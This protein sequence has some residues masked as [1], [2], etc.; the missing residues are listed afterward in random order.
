[1]RV[2][3]TLPPLAWLAREVG[4][5]RLEVLA[6][7]DPR[8]DPEV[9]MLTPAA[10]RALANADVVFAVG[11]GVLPF[12]QQILPSLVRAG[13]PHVVAVLTEPE[14]GGE[15]PR[16]HRDHGAHVTRDPHAWLDP[17]RMLDAAHRLT[18]RLAELDPPAAP[19]YRQSLALL[20]A[21]VQEVDE[22]IR[23]R[24]AASDGGVLL[25]EHPTWEVLARR[26]RTTVL[27]IE[28]EEREPSARRLREVIETARSARVRT[29]AIGGGGRHRLA[30]TV[31]R[32]IGAAVVEVEPLAYDWLD[33]LERAAA[34]AA[35]A[36]PSSAREPSDPQGP[37]REPSDPRSPDG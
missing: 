28:Q 22:R 6:L 33:S 9:G 19:R 13:A 3:A 17:E 25:S 26:Y 4:G 20:V 11:G 24:L 10:A 34:L 23:G 15:K 5:D 1:M 21:R 8:S 18:D 36:S 31:A 35:A 7:L 14:A 12:E 27:T 29:L 2:V 32:E 30:R 16:A 37:D